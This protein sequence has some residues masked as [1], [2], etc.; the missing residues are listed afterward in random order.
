[1]SSH[2]SLSFSIPTKIL[3]FVYPRYPAYLILR[4][5]I[6]LMISDEKH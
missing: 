2:W 4:D 5:V 1:M 3:Y 6:T